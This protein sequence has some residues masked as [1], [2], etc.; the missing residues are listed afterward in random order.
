MI[1]SFFIIVPTVMNLQ[2]CVFIKSR[3]KKCS[4]DECLTSEESFF[5]ALLL[6]MCSDALIYSFI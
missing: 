4:S 2:V 5:Y 6:F 1:L 3:Y